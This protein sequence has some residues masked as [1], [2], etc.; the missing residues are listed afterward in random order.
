MQDKNSL[1]V[2]AGYG[3]VEMDSGREHTRIPVDS[4]SEGSGR[5][6]VLDF[7]SV[8]KISQKKVE[9]TKRCQHSSD[10]LKGRRDGHAE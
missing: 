8:Q 2:F 5:T 6:R 4:E 9:A 7:T 1:G 3:E 10:R